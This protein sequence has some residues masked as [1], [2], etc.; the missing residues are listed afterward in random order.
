MLIP[1]KVKTQTYFEEVAARLSALPR[2]LQMNNA[3]QTDDLLMQVVL[4]LRR[5]TEI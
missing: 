3:R 5:D 4:L 2:A 1:E